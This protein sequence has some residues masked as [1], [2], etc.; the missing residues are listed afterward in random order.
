MRSAS[1][2]AVPRPRSV[3]TSPSRPMWTVIAGGIAVELRGVLQQVPHR[4]FQALA[5]PSY[6]RGVALHLDVATGAAVHELRG[7]VHNPC[8]VDGLLGLV[9]TTS[10]R[11]CDQLLDQLRQFP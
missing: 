1:A 10:Q 9:A 3:T 7:P 2:A 8:Q 6:D 4:P 11:Q 5:L